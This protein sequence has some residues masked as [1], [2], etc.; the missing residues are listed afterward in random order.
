MSLVGNCGSVTMTWHNPWFKGLQPR[1]PCSGHVIQIFVW[2]F[3]GRLRFPRLIQA[4]K[5]KNGAALRGKHLSNRVKGGLLQQIAAGGGPG[6]ASQ[7]T[8]SRSGT[9]DSEPAS[10]AG[11]RSGSRGSSGQ[12][13]RSGTEEPR[14]N[15]GSGS[16]TGEPLE[17]QNSLNPS[18]AA[19]QRGL[20]VCVY[21]C[22]CLSVVG[23]CPFCNACFCI[24]FKILLSA[25]SVILVCWPV[26]LA[27]WWRQGGHI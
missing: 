12:A 11:G 27:G 24:G 6:E 1:V 7:G 5:K 18:T 17:R 21:W 25:A 16:E 19:V 22:E 9:E 23:V 13:S 15:S 2:Q 4:G 10:G 14:Q 20:Q 3:K 8:R 26:E